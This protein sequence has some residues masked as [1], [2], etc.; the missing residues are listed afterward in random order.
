MATGVADCALPVHAL[1]IQGDR[2]GRREVKALK[3]GISYELQLPRPWEP[4]G[5]IHFLEEYSP[6]PAPDVPLA[7]LPDDIHPIWREGAIGG[8]DRDALGKRLRD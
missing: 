5:R 3:L 2:R 8:D 4:D 7:S 6:S 1:C